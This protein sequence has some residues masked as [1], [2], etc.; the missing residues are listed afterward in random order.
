MMRLLTSRFSKECCV[1]LL[2][3]RILVGFPDRV[4]FVIVIEDLGAQTADIDAVAYVARLLRLAAA[5]DTSTRTAHDLD[6]M[7]GSFT[8][9]D[10]FKQLSCVS[11]TGGDGYLNFQTCYRI[12]GFLDAFHAADVGEVQ[13]L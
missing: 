3:C 8:G 13:I 4:V 1:Q 12:S 9:F 6:E 2:D 5:V 10:L 11:K 7:I